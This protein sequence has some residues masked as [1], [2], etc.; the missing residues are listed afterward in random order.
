MS[1]LLLIILIIVGLLYLMMGIIIFYTVVWNLVF[2][3]NRFRRIFRGKK[4]ILII[5]FI[6][7]VIA[8]F[9]MS[10]LLIAILGSEGDSW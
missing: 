2:Q 4:I 10:K 3:R 1:P 6:P 5:V 8:G 9:L 7:F